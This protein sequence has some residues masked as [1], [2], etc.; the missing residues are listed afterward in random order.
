MKFTKMMMAGLAIAGLAA[1]ALAL[2]EDTAPKAEKRVKKIVITHQDGSTREVDVDGIRGKAK[3]MADAKC[4]E[5][6]QRFESSDEADKDGEKKRYRFVFC[7]NGDRLA[8][9]EK[10]RERFAERGF[11]FGGRADALDALDKARTRIAES[12]DLEEQARAKALAAL[13]T[14]IDRL[15]AGRE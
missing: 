2:E 10:M 4:A 1:P 7:G 11:P 12:Q 13:D 14:E 3:S 6:E 15:K 5:A 9:L 8:M